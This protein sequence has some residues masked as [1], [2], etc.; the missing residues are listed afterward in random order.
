M[1]VCISIHNKHS[2]DKIRF[3]HFRRAQS[4]RVVAH[5]PYLPRS[6]RLNLD[7]HQSVYSYFAFNISG[8]IPL[9]TYTI[10]DHHARSFARVEAVGFEIVTYKRSV[11]LAVH[12]QSHERGFG[13]EELWR[14]AFVHWCCVCVCVM[15][16]YAIMNMYVR[17]YVST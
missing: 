10:W 9:D 12:A 14:L 15:F 17:W 8:R 13:R 16:M 4:R 5:N 1:Y 3:D 6:V 7:S 11:H 2:L